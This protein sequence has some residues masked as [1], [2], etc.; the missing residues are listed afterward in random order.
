MNDSS[1]PEFKRPKILIN[2][3]P[4]DQNSG[5]FVSMPRFWVDDF[6]KSCTHWPG[7][8]TTK[9]KPIKGAALPSSFW[10]YTLYLWRNVSVGRQRKGVGPYSYYTTISMDEY[11]VRGE[12]A[13]QWT[14]AY[15]V[16]GV[17]D[18]QMGAWSPDHKDS[19]LFTYNPATPETE[20]RAFL[21]ALAIA[22]DGWKG[23]RYGKKHDTKSDVSFPVGPNAG[24]W[25]VFAASEV[26]KQRTRQG[27]GP[28]NTKYLDDAVSGNVVDAWG[29]PIAQRDKDGEIQPILY[30]AIRRRRPG[31]TEDEWDSRTT[32]EMYD[33]KGR[34]E[35]GGF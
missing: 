19:T 9:G 2:Y 6:F 33:G 32:V 12:Q 16:S 18:V 11:P 13:V 17:M 26:D 5:A 4:A 10:R 25:K 21:Q 24:A 23:L 20:W 28:V 7:T 3:S 15:A 1:K 27:L 30:S 22:C 34:E 14:A 31:E 8:T 35:R 29:R